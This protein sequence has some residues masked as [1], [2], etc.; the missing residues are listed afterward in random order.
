MKNKESPSKNLKDGIDNVFILVNL[1]SKR[2]RELS[3]GATKLI[4]TECDDPMQIALKEIA[5]GKVTFN[6]KKKAAESRAKK[7]K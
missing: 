6:Q 3:S 5:Q 4:Q 2:G 1:A 7:G